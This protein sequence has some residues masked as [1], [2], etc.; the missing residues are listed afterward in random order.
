MPT[1]PRPQQVNITEAVYD[2]E[3]RSTTYWVEAAG[4]TIMVI[5]PDAAIE[6]RKLVYALA[7][8]EVDLEE[9]PVNGPQVIGR[10]IVDDVPDADERALDAIFAEHFDR[11][12]QHDHDWRTQRPGRPDDPAYAGMQRRE[13][14]RGQRNLPSRAPEQV[15]P[16]ERMVVNRGRPQDD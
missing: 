4:H 2:P 9:D 16:E 3:T 14:K 13:E 12:E 1:P 7:H 5:V 10:R 11:F 6:N 8:E 15:D